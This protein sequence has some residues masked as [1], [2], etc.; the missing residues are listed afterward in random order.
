MK[1]IQFLFLLF[2]ILAFVSCGNLKN[3]SIDEVEQSVVRRQSGSKVM[4]ETRVKVN[5]PTGHKLVLRKIDAE[6]LRNG[7]QFANVKLKE[8]VKVLPHSNDYHSVFVE[9]NV[10]DIMAVITKTVDLTR[11]N[12]NF[13]ATGF[14]KGG[15]GLL[16]K[17]FKFTDITM[18][19]LENLLYGSA[20]FVE[21]D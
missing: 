9:F 2:V 1:L 17:K 8:K 5:N 16:C 6:I 13:T 3:I 15:T 11:L 10:I 12:D 20:R 7:Y 19:Q 18:S 4:V 14:I 21:E